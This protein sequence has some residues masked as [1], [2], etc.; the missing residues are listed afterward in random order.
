MLK[1]LEAGRSVMLASPGPSR[2]LRI[3]ESDP[4]IGSV[5]SM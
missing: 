1:R 3:I 4:A 5:A 2:L